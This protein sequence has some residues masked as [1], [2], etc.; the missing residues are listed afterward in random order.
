M[1]APLDLDAIRRNHPLPSVVGATVKLIRAGNEFK[2]LRDAGVKEIAIA[3]KNG[4]SWLVEGKT[5]EKL[6]RLRAGIERGI[7]TLKMPKYGFNR[8][9]ARSERMMVACGHRAMM[10]MNLS[11]MLRDQAAA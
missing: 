2:A 11:R 5:R 6:I 7:G 9:A 10:G 3:P 4:G 1:N 8:P